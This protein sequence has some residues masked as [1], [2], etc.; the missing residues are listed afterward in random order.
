MSVDVA[1]VARRG[2]FAL[3]VKFDIAK[4]GVTALFGPSGAGKTSIVDAIAGLMKPSAGRIVINGRTVFDRGLGIDVAVRERRV[5]YVF[6]D[7]RLF[8]HMNVERNLLF[9]WRRAKSRA[10]ED[11]IARVIDI[12][13]I[14][15]LR[16][17]STRALSGGERQ[18]VAIGRALL[19]SPEILLLDE[20][21]AALDV[22]R[23]G[24]IFPYLERLRDARRIPILLVSHAIDEV[25]RLAD[26]VVVLNDGRV[27]AQ[28]SVFDLM[29]RID[30]RAGV[31]LAVTV[32]RHREDG[33]TELDIGS[34]KLLVRRLDAASGTRLRVRIEAND[35]MLSLHP[36]TEV[37]ANNVLSAAVSNL[38]AAGSGLVDVVLAVGSATLTARVTEASVLRLALKE[39]MPL[40]AVIK[41]VT[42][43]AG[44]GA[45]S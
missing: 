30:P 43:D 26:S 25:A 22:A 9:G 2:T 45:G 14:A 1:M 19:S 3:D 10:S 32:A 17:R 18:R 38:R 37:S 16:R 27:M 29:P 21:M 15:H 7:A 20:P 40:F 44:M 33:L 8:P 36:L 28:G 35:V 24:E 12:L 34:G 31:V 11:E 6:Q 42:V 41:A 13:G 5:G 39:G 23:R 4:S